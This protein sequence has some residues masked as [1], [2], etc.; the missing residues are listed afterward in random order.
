MYTLN[1]LK[2]ELSKRYNQNVDLDILESCLHIWNIEPVNNSEQNKEFFDEVTLSKINRGLK[3]KQEGYCE[4][5]IPK[6]LS[7]LTFKPKCECKQEVSL[8]EKVIQKV[9]EAIKQ[10][11]VEKNIAQEKKQEELKNQTNPSKVV[12]QETKETQVV[13]SKPEKNSGKPKGTP[14]NETEKQ[15]PVNHKMIDI[16]SQSIADKVSLEILSYLQDGDLYEDL[17]KMSSLK[18]D[19]EI[20]S[21]QVEELIRVNGD[22]ENKVFSL[23][24]EISNY[25]KLWKN[26][27][28]K[29]N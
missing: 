5:V 22:L 15:N 16:L 2:D 27:Y 23:E 8:E 9:E 28:L 1:Q 4:S 12:K 11:E 24:L 7:K 21:K 10:K 6:I 14:P 29:F 19:N 25:K 26:L 3:L 17:M 13:N 20:L 18:R